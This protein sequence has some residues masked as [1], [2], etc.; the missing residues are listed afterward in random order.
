MQKREFPQDFHENGRKNR[1]KTLE[2]KVDSLR[3]FLNYHSTIY[4]CLE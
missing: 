2:D 4:G 3:L 1:K